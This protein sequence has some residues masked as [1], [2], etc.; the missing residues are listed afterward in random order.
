MGKICVDCGCEKANNWRERC[1]VCGRKKAAKT[2]TGFKHSQKTK[3]EMSESRKGKNTWMKGRK[4]TDET[5]KKMSDARKGKVPW[6]KGKKHSEETKEKIKDRHHDV[7]GSN[8]PMYGKKHSKE[9]KE[10]IA[11]SSRKSMAK[12][13]MELTG[14][15]P[16]YNPTACRLIEEYGKEH[17]YNFQHAEKGG[18]FYIKGLGYFVDGYD[19][20]KNTV[21]EYYE[22]WHKRQTK[23]DLLRQERIEKHLNC[24]FIILKGK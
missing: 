3:D 21:I 5:R 8:N 9:T 24:K 22:K 12:R 16:N 13:F 11:V 18:E 20:E 14:N 6:N 19:K 1:M 10:K 15:A 4:H 17:G 23:K 2:N 7:S